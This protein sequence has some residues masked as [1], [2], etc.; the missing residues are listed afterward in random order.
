MLQS[1]MNIMT[2]GIGLTACSAAIVGA[3]EYYQYAHSAHPTPHFPTALLLY[4]LATVCEAA[5]EKYMVSCV[6]NYR[7]LRIGVVEVTSIIPKT[8]FVLAAAW[9][10]WFHAHGLLVFGA[11]QLVYSATMMTTFWAMSPL[12]GLGAAKWGE[13]GEQR[14]VDPVSRKALGEFGVM[15]VLK[16]VLHEFEKIVLVFMDVPHISSTYS[17]ISNLGSVVVRYLFAPLN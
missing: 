15:S 8:L 9:L 5:A 10:G 12:K 17:L 11:A 14:W 6:L 2:A 7:Y 3:I 1:G 4:C 16:L 13:E